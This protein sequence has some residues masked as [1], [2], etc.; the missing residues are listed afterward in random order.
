MN[1]LYS[2]L[3]AGLVLLAAD[4]ASA[5][6]PWRG[7]Y[8]RRQG[9]F[10]VE[11]LHWGGGINP[12]GAQ[13][14]MHGFDVAGSTLPVILRPSGALTT[15]ARAVA[16]GGDSESLVSE[17]GEAEDLGIPP[18]TPGERDRMAKMDEVLRELRD[19][20][21]HLPRRVPTEA[22]PIQAP[23]QAPSKAPPPPRPM[24]PD[25]GRGE[26]ENPGR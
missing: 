20:H 19:I 24:D 2:V 11:R 3:F 17:A 1:R 6:L 22:A 13:V 7:H 5:Q 12:Y 9:L 4:Q 14:L 25:R 18:L 8:V 15:G 26:S 23:S 21:A 10:H 16:A